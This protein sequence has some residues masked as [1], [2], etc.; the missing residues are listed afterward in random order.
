MDL[1]FPD[2][3][4]VEQ[5]NRV[6]TG[7]VKYH[8][9]TANVTP[10]RSTVLT[11]LDAS[12]ASWTGYAAVTQTWTDYTINGVAA[13]NGYALAPPI[14][15]ANTSGSTQNP[16]GYYVTNTG[17]TILLACA[18]F[19]GAPTPILTGTSLLLVPVWGDF[20]RLGA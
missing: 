2:A 3:G 8:L 20:S 14:S 5:L 11:D 16:Y 4:L 1:I 17:S 10:T 7:S 15:F 13:H 19:D 9:Y 18:R 6:L 12:E